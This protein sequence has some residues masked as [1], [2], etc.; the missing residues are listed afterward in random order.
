MQKKKILIG[1]I[2][3]IC[4]VI[5][6]I[7]LFIFSYTLESNSEKYIFKTGKSRIIV[8]DANTNKEITSISLSS[9][10]EN[11]TVELSP[12]DIQM[13]PSK[14]YVWVTAS[15]SQDQL[16]ALHKNA[17]E[18]LHLMMTSD[19]VLVIDLSTN[20]VKKRLQMGNNIHLSDLVFTPDNK[21]TYIA[22]EK[23]NAIYKINTSNYTVEQMIQLPP[24]SLPHEMA[25]SE[26]TE[27][28][29]TRNSAGSNIFVIST[30]NDKLISKMKANDALVK[31]INW[32]TH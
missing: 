3:V 19:Q 13:T 29:Y 12:H 4:I 16:S 24:E 28:L 20:T 11:I 23:G 5:G 21:Y 8:E 18:H 27:S 30:K 17:K 14:K 25:L 32:S 7:S 22:A 6:S 15:A 31:S 2:F 26:D 9:T 1:F 10:E